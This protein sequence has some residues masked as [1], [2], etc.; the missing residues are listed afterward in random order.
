MYKLSKQQIEN[1]PDFMAIEGYEGLYEVGKDGSVWSLDYRRTGQRKQL[2]AN[3]L[4]QYGHLRVNLCKDGE[5]KTLSVHQ[6][7]M[8]AYLPKP[9]EDSEVLHLNSDPADNR[10]ENLAWGTRRENMNDPHFLTLVSTPVLC[11][12]TG[13]AYP[14]V[15]EAEQQTSISSGSISACCKVKH[16]TAGGYHW[17]KVDDP[18]AMVLMPTYVLCVETGVMYPTVNKASQQTGVHPTYIYKCLNGK[19]KTAGRFHWQKVKDC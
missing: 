13:V 7:V 12:E 1:A 8:N 9:S 17:L 6:L 16:K 3:T 14:S 19:Q 4:N 11:V 15:S 18:Q 2:K 5:Q 10:L